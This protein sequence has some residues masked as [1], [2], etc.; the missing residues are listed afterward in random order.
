MTPLEFG[1]RHG[2]YRNV[3]ENRAMRLLVSYNANMEL[4][5]HSAFG[6]EVLFEEKRPSEEPYPSFQRLRHEVRRRQKKIALASG[7]HS[8]LGAESRIQSL[9]PEILHYIMECAEL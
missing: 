4:K 2:T 5:A 3:D 9:D 6:E 8:R 1:Q 7:L